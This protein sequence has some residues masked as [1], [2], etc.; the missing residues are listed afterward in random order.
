MSSVLPIVVMAVLIG[1]NAVFVAAEFA[2]IAAP[3]VAIRQL[4]E[5]GNRLAGVV[6]RIQE[7]PRLQ[8]RYLATTQLGIT[9]AS[10]GLGMY[11][12]HLLAEWIAAG[13]G[14]LGAGRWM[15]AHTLASLLAVAVLSYFHV[16]VGEI[17]PK[18]V[19]LQ[20]PV[21]TALWV[22]PLLRAFQWVAYPL[23]LVLNALGTAVLRLFGVRRE[24]SAERFRTP[25]EI[26]TIVRESQAGGKLRKTSAEVIQELID[27][28]NLSAG[29]VMVPR[30]RTVAL[31]LG[32][33]PAEVRDALRSSPFTRYPVFED[34]IDRI[35]GVAH[36]KD[37]LRFLPKDRTLAAGD[38]HPVAFLPETA[39]LER[40]LAGMREARSQ[41]AVVMDEHGGTAGIVTI[42]D[43]FEEVVGAVDEERSHVPETHRDAE[44]RLRVLGTVRVEDLG[45]L[46][47]VVL[48]HPEVD[49]VSG[50]VLALLDRPPVVGDEVTYEEVLLRVTAVQDHGVRE[51]V[52]ERVEGRETEDAGGEKGAEE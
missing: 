38:V 48:E 6:A 40:V 1:I 16:V 36:V 11:G 18:G 23:V 50:L 41:L 30:V 52:A 5:A 34:T 13:L 7:S 9:G 43:L 35:V 20:R 21:R 10:L 42:E 51:C 22:A 8:D 47:G 14:D 12:E 39:S 26:E 4:A 25:E 29:E 15:A 33:T 3:R 24:G 32:S 45:E 19:A 2:I 37:L 49:T 46:L 44:G 27:W 31:P 28:G 17:I